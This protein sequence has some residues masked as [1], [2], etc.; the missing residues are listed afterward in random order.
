MCVPCSD[1][2]CTA[3][4]TVGILYMLSSLMAAAL[5]HELGELLT[6]AWLC[7][8]SYRVEWN[9]RSSSASLLSGLVFVL[10][11]LLYA[12]ETPTGFVHDADMTGTQPQLM[13]LLLEE[14]SCS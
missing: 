9:A 7:Q 2:P 12:F 3:V 14:A 10:L 11:T 6:K 13:V 8:S 4:T 1:K 5:F